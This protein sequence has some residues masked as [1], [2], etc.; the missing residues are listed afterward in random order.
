MTHYSTR[1]AKTLM[2]YLY[3]GGA[4][5][6]VFDKRKG[7]IEFLRFGYERIAYFRYVIQVD[8]KGYSVT[9][10][11]PIAPCSKDAAAMAAIA[12]Y[13]SLINETMAFGTN[14]GHLEGYFDLDC[15]D[16]IITFKFFVDC[17]MRLIASVIRDSIEWPEIDMIRA[18]PGILDILFCG[19]TAE[20]ALADYHQRLESSLEILLPKENA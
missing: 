1:I 20:A 12:E 10:H 11:C 17:Y 19:K 6:L 8:K 9:L 2:R 18:V 4:Q 16:G 7:K 13:L 15:H 3:K 5:M 14:G